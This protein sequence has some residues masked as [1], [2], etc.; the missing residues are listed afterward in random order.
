METQIWLSHF[1]NCL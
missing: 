1:F